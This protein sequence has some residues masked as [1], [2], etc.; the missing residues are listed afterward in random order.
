MENRSVENWSVEN[1]SVENR[2]VENRSVENHM[3]LVFLWGFKGRHQ[4]L[5]TLIQA[6]GELQEWLWHSC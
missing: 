5:S 2:S 4:I 6:R 3:R 1:R